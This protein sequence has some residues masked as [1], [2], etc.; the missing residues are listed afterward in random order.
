[1]NQDE[2]WTRWRT[3]HW[4]EH[5]YPLWFYAH[6]CP[7]CKAT[8]GHWCRG[9]GNKPPCAIRVRMGEVFGYP[10]VGIAKDVPELVVKMLEATYGEEHGE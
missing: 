4:S 2:M 10:D 9:D 7:V 8:A 3:E 1:M 5:V 6:A